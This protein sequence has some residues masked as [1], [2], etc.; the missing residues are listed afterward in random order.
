M[1]DFKFSNWALCFSERERPHNASG[2]FC[3]SRRQPAMRAPSPRLQFNEAMA[4]G[5]P[6]EAADAPPSLR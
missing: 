1:V 6:W 4:G 3:F 2:Q 5:P